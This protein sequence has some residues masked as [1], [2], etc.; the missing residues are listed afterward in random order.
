MAIPAGAALVIIGVL[1]PGVR[2]LLQ[3]NGDVVVL[4]LVAGLAGM[5]SYVCGHGEVPED[6]ASR[7]SE[8]D[9]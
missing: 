6:Q 9:S 3:S 7:P 2:A 8:L 5:V 1:H 4:F